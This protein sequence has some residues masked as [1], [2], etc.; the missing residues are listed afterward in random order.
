MADFS[1]CTSRTCR[2]ETPGIVDKCPTCGSKVQTS[3]RIRV[4]GWLSIACGVILIGLMGYVTIA[5]YPSLSNPGVADPDGGRWT[6]GA[7]AARMSLNLFY[8][9]IGFGVLAL[10]SGAWMVATGRRHIAITV[11]TLLAAGVLIFQGWETTQA[12]KNAQEAE[13]PRRYVQPPAAPDLSNFSAPA[14]DKPQ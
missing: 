10:A 4:L 1:I 11:V 5:M 2:A 8:V 7:E 12:L 14:P 3:R 6:G 9:V 13:E